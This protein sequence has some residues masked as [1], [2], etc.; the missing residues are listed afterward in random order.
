[1][2]TNLTTYDD[3]YNYSGYNFYQSYRNCNHFHDPIKVGKYTMYASASTDAPTGLWTPAQRPDLFIGLSSTWESLLT[4]INTNVPEFTMPPTVPYAIL[5]WA[6]QDACPDNILQFVVPKLIN[7]I[8][9]GQAIEVGCMG[10]H[11]RTGTLLAILLGKI[12]KLKPLKA[13]TELRKRYCDSAVE[14]MRQIE[15]VYV[16]LGSTVKEAN[17]HFEIKKY[18]YQ[19][20]I[21]EPDTKKTLTINPADMSDEDWN[22]YIKDKYGI[23]PN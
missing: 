12:E 16:A 7:R 10:G 4:T 13:I 5:S 22:K 14:S 8:Q 20:P 11:G 15:Q 2:N 6:D 19:K 23:E 1:M 21:T 17:K 18:T 3:Y 9:N